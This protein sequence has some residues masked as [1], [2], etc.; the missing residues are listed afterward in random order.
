[1]AIL[2]EMLKRIFG[3]E[4]EEVTIGLQKLH[5]EKLCNMYSS[6]NTARVIEPSRIKWVAHVARTGDDKFKLNLKI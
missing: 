1:L 3:S 6:H 5:I 2:K 4:R